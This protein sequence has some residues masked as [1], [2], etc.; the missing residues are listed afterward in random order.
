M[1]FSR[2]FTL[3]SRQRS[4]TKNFA[5][6]HEANLLALA[7]G[8]TEFARR[9]ISCDFPC[10]RDAFPL[11]SENRALRDIVGPTSPVWNNTRQGLISHLLENPEGMECRDRPESRRAFTDDEAPI[12]QI[13]Q[14]D[15][16]SWHMNSC[17][18]GWLL[19]SFSHQVRP[20]LRLTTCLAGPGLTRR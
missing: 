7:I 16:G 19:R 2:Y 12:G 20:V 9:L 4:L 10:W 17:C 13:E 6:F 18:G 5:A 11:A 15:D 1:I 3:F 8:S 14:T